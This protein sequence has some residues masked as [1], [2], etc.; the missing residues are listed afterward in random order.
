MDPLILGRLR[1][2]KGQRPEVDVDVG[3]TCC[4]TAATDGSN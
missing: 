2:A 3:V 4:T 1:G